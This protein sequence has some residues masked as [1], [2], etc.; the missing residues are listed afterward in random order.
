MGVHIL[1]GYIRPQQPIIVGLP[2]HIL[3]LANN[4]GDTAS[5][6]EPNH[7]TGLELHRFLHFLNTV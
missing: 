7:I 4:D 2:W 6:L 5:P 1:V 3:T